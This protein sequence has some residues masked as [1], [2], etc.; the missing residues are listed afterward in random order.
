VAALRTDNGQPTAPAPSVGQLDELVS[1]ARATGLTVR[2]VVVGSPRV[3][4]AVVDVAAARIV[5]ESLTNVVRHSRSPEASVGIDY[6]PD[7]LTVTVVDD[8]PSATAGTASGGSGIAGM[9]ERVLALGGTL[10][11]QRSGDGFAVRASF[12]LAAE[13]DDSSS[14]PS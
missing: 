7:A 11:A 6:G 14:A 4:P 9:R 3:L 8:G 12:P 1:A 5:Q 2:T 10:S 13:I